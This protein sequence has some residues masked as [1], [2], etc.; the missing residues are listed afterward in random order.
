MAARYMRAP[1]ERK[2]ASC[3]DSSYGGPGAGTRT[4]PPGARPC[5]RAAAG[6]R[7][8]GAGGW[9]LSARGA[10]PA[11]T[12]TTEVTATAD[13]H[14]RSDTP[15]SRYGTL[16]ELWADSSPTTRSYL[17]LPGERC[18][19]HRHARAA[20]RAREHGHTAASRSGGDEHHLER[21]HDQLLERP[22]RLVDDRTATQ[23]RSPPAPGRTSTSPRWSPATARTAWRSSTT[24]SANL[25][26]SSRETGANAPR[27]VIESDD[28]TPP[29][30]TLSSGPPAP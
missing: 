18:E 17:P 20:A 25:V 29:Q 16:S 30:T 7:G 23:G 28:T 9:R 2:V 5:R 4:G 27:L 10:A 14:V 19:R 21:E 13:A 8:G 12:V 1:T 3:E 24:S 11:A 22:V 6:R 15:S 26:L